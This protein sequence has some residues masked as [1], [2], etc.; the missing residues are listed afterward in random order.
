MNWLIFVPIAIALWMLS[1][2]FSC[3]YWQLKVYKYMDIYW[4]AFLWALLS[5]P[6]E[7]YVGSQVFGMFKD[8]PI[9]YVLWMERTYG[10]KRSKV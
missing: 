9:S 10:T 5:G 3:L 4:V 8:N 1:G 7:W 6:F 2:I